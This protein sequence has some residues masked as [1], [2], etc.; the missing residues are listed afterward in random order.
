[1]I[2]TLNTATIKIETIR[3]NYALHKWFTCYAAK[4]DMAISYN[5]L[6]L[7]FWLFTSYYFVQLIEREVLYF[8]NSK[9]QTSSKLHKVWFCNR[10]KNN[11][12][13]WSL[14]FCSRAFKCGEMCASYKN[15]SSFLKF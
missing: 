8:S 13:V 2:D 14:H 7:R 9:V 5:V 6:Y 15:K 4:H 10:Y 3:G 12:M 11:E 1:M